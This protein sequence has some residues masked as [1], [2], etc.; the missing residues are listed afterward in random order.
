MTGVVES[1]KNDLAFALYCAHCCLRKER[2][3]YTQFTQ[4]AVTGSSPGGSK[5]PA[6][7]DGAHTL[8]CFGIF[9][10]KF[11]GCLEGNKFR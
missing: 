6:T 10:E 9:L 4:H 8:S 2:R 11:T 3:G 1:T 5:R 7:D